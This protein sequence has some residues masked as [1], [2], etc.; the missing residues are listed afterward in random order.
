MTAPLNSSFRTAQVVLDFVNAVFGRAD[1]TFPRHQTAQV[2][3]QAFVPDTGR[4]ILLP[5]AT[6]GDVAAAIA[7]AEALAAVLAELLAD[8]AACPG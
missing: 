1:A 7:E 6:G 8:P 2:E 3:G 4:V 5:L